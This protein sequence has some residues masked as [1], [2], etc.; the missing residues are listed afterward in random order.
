MKTNRLGAIGFWIAGKQVGRGRTAPLGSR[1]NW[2]WHHP[3]FENP[4]EKIYLALG[5]ASFAAYKRSIHLNWQKGWMAAGLKD[6]ENDSS[7]NG[8]RAD[9]RNRK[10]PKYAATLLMATRL[11]G[12]DQRPHHLN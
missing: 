12:D 11:L 9:R 3:P 6:W 2:D 4:K 5:S 7:I 1:K 10:P 8:L